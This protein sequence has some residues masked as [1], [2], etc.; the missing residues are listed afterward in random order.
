MMVVSTRKVYAYQVVLG[1]S[2]PCM[3]PVFLRQI[4]QRMRVERPF[5]TLRIVLDNAKVHKTALMKGLASSTG[6]IF[7]F[8]ASHSPFM[9]P[10][11]FCFCFMKAGFRNDHFI[12]ELAKKRC[13]SH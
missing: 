1:K 12:S 5:E 8:T 7:I 11:V 4:L 6:A 13:A 9:N 10:I 3:I 2:P